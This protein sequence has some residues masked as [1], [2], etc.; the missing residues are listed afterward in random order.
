MTV[1]RMKFPRNRAFPKCRNRSPA[2][3]MTRRNGPEPPGSGP[4]SR[5]VK[6]VQ[7]VQMAPGNSE[8][9][10]G[11]PGGGEGPTR[12]GG[13]ADFRQG[14]PGS[15]GD[16]RNMQAGPEAR[17]SSGKL[18][19]RAAADRGELPA[20]GG[21]PRGGPPGGDSSRAPGGPSPR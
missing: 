3:G 2:S 8:R 13:P 9:R 5:P 19:R 6:A 11:E 14:Q 17:A 10:V 15:G 16:R 7:H 1:K 20:G 18:E 21:R 4:V 12:G